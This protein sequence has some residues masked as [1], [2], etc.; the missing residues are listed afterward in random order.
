MSYIDP[1]SSSMAFQFIIAG[2]LGLVVTFW[3][4]IVDRCKRIFGSS[5]NSE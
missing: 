4:R 3:R 1:G 5:R 2:A